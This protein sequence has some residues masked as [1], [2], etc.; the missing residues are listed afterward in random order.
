MSARIRCPK[1]EVARAQEKKSI[2]WH[3]FRLLDLF[4]LQRRDARRQVALLDV[5]VNV[6]QQSRPI[7]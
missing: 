7:V 4:F 6:A 5:V 2:L 3:R 1:S